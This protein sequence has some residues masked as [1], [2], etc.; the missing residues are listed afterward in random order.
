MSIDSAAMI[1]HIVSVRIYGQVYAVYGIEI[2]QL[3]IPVARRINH[4]AN[5]NW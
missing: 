3:K 2:N 1:Q 5:S 4:L